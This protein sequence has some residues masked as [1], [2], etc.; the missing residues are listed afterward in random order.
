MSIAIFEASDKKENPARERD[1]PFTK[2]YRFLLFFDF[3]AALR[4]FAMVVLNYEY[5]LICRPVCPKKNRGANV[6]IR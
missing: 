5:Q 1:F 6:S 2:N 4:F 3:F